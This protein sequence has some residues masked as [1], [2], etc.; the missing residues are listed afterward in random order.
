MLT[1]GRFIIQDHCHDILHPDLQSSKFYYLQCKINSLV[2]SWVAWHHSNNDIRNSKSLSWYY[3]VSPAKLWN[4]L[5]AMLNQTLAISL[6]RLKRFKCLL[7]VNSQLKNIVLISTMEACKA[8]NS[9]VRN[10]KSM[11]FFL[12]ALTPA[13]CT[14]R[15]RFL[16]MLHR[17][18]RSFEMYHL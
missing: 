12:N 6:R 2:S 15:N 13:E 5:F 7:I 10:A 4:A 1:R 3:Q 18:L 8:P 16:G 9:T 17:A 11:A 14:T